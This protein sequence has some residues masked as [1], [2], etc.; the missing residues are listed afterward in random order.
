MWDMNLKLFNINV[1]SQAPCWVHYA[2]K[3]LKVNENSA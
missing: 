3:L 2:H 1:T